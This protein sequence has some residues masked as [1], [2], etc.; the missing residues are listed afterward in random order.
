[1]SEKRDYY[2][3]LGIPKT[4]SDDEIK[5]AFRRLA[6]QYH[7]DVNKDDPNAEKKFKEVNEAYEVLSDPQKRA[8]YDH[9][10]HA[11]TDPNFGQGFGG[12]GGFGDFGFDGV[13]DIFDMFFGGGGRR[14]RNGPERGADLRYDMEITFEDAAFGTTRTIEVPR[15]EVCPECSGNRAKPGTPITTCPNCKGSG[16]VRVA[17]NTA[18]GRFVNVTTCSRCQGEGKII[19]TPCPAC[20]GKGRVRRSRKIE[21]KIP[22]GVDT[23]SKLRMSGE[24]EAGTRGGGPGDLYIFIAVKPHA[25]FRRQG[26][27]VLSE[28]KIGLAQAALGTTVVVSTLDGDVD[29][30]IP[31]GT[32]TDTVFR[33][34]GRGITHLRGHGRGD[35]HVRVKVV[36]PTKL[37]KEQRD[38]LLRYA[39]ASGED[40]AGEKGILGKVKDVLGK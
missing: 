12:A 16:Q 6:R 18:F 13:G 33:L 4:A 29:L 40:I 15:N 10:G 21:V 22:A 1:M 23:G 5:K 26:D 17:Q 36:V 32:Q 20:H 14:Q 31:E 11:G 3:V 27:D 38:A 30:K 39:E 28:V 24:G 34:R 35:Q 7:P 37:S 25:H 9:Y 8:A 2:E 19:E